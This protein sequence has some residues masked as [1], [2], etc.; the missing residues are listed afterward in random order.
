MKTQRDLTIWLL[1]V[2][3]GGCVAKIEL[4]DDDA[5]SSSGDASPT[6]TSASSTTPTSTESVGTDDDTS[7]ESTGAPAGWCLETIL[8]EGETPPALPIVADVDGDGVPELW[9]S[10]YAGTVATLSPFTV[11]IDGTVSALAPS[12]RDGAFRRFADIDGDGLDDGV[13]E[14]TDD[15]L[16]WL[17]GRSDA[18]LGEDPLPLSFPETTAYGAAWSDANGDGIADV[19]RARTDPATI[20]LWIGDGDGGFELVQEQPVVGVDAFFAHAEIIPS[21]EPPFLPEV[22]G[23]ALEIDNGAI[24]FGIE[25]ALAVATVDGS[26]MLQISTATD[27]RPWQRAIGIG[28]LDGQAP[29][30]LL[31]VVDSREVVLW[32]GA[33]GGGFMP[34]PIASLQDELTGAAVGDFRG[35]GTRDI[36][37][38]TIDG[39]VFLYPAPVSDDVVGLEVG[40]TLDSPGYYAT[41][42]VDGDGR[43]EL[44][45]TDAEAPAR[46]VRIVEC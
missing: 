8:L 39:A 36:L 34:Q 12:I 24:G 10:E 29:A 46:L 7:G 15:T 18:T 42:D 17:P 27:Y 33:A 20:E 2:G 5:S 43:T 25:R 4:G 41:I 1:V 23:F 44:Y 6:T 31:G 22:R 37:V 45:S 13:F 19:L 30:D 3:L 21:T 16:W 11:A 40:G 38:A 14:G 32:H 26:S 35:D 9:S 28:E